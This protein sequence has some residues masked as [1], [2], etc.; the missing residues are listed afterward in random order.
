MS[1]LIKELADILYKL[2]NLYYETKSEEKK[3]KI[4]THFNNLSVQ[5]ERAIRSQFD[6]NDA[7]Y[8][9]VVQ[10]LKKAGN[11]LKKLKEDLEKIT[12]IFK[13]LT[14]LSQQLDSLLTKSKD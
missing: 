11:Q 1:D 12:N 14:D 7:L 6:E 4:K 5:L 13:L 3:E 8:K 9:V 10:Q 2:D